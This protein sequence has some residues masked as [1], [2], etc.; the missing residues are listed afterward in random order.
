M[1]QKPFDK[2]ENSDIEAL[3]SNE[4]PEGRK[5]D[6]KEALPGPTDAEKKEFLAD[7]SSFAN[8]AGGDLVF[9][10][11]E[12]RDEG[13]PTALPASIEGLPGI[14]ADQEIRRLEDLVR[15]GLDPTIIGI[16]LR[17]VGPFP[18]GHQVV[19]LRVPKSWSSPHMVCLKGSSRFW[20]RD[21]RGKHPMD[22]HEIRHAF[23]LSEGLP[24]K[25][26]RFRDERLARII[27]GETPVMMPDGPKIVLHLLPIAALDPTTRLNV[28]PLSRMTSELKPL[29]TGEW[30]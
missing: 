4:V 10:V 13:K 22:V 18:N 15:T 21:N 5:L 16:Q 27:A 6:Y 20:T 3:I 8:A 11:R 1:I 28:A 12:R 26:R 19:L 17:P 23:A 24:V 2:I 30:G 14:N 25:V 9:G 29:F 7:V